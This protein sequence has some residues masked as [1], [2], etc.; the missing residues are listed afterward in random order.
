MRGD[1][2]RLDVRAK[3]KK[4]PRKKEGRRERKK[5]GVRRGRIRGEASDTTIWV[6][7]ICCH[8][9]FFFFSLSAFFSRFLPAILLFFSFHFPCRYF[10]FFA[11]FFMGQTSPY[12]R[13][14]YVCNF[15]ERTRAGEESSP[16]EARE[17]VACKKK[18]ICG[19]EERYNCLQCCRIINNE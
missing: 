11:F 13:S 7:V 12:S 3:D 19:L 14:R 18:C 4:K 1:D 8:Q 9:R 16:E 17:N 15:R 6:R 5:E 2:R 10:F